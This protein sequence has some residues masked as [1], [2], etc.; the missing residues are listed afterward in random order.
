MNQDDGNALIIKLRPASSTHH[1]QHVYPANINLLL[2]TM[3]DL[4]NQ[5]MM[6]CRLC[7]QCPLQVQS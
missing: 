3:S 6:H 4:S 7:P 2:L 5:T 1:L